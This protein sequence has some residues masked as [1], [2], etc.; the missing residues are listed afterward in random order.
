ME[1]FL[2]GPYIVG[3][4]S[5]CEHE[6]EEFADPAKN[7]YPFEF[8]RICVGCGRFLNADPDLIECLVKKWLSERDTSGGGHS[9]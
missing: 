7:P 5:Y 1:T 9:I 2:R 6:R 8:I 4:C 3:R